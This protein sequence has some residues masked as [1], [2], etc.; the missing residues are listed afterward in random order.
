MKSKNN[1]DLYKSISE[2]MLDV[3]TRAAIA[4]ILA[5]LALLFALYLYLAFLR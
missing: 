3:N 5:I 4:F 1:I 2:A